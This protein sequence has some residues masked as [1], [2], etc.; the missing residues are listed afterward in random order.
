MRPFELRPGDPANRDLLEQVRPE[1]WSNPDPIERYDIAVLGAGTA[2]LVTAF[3]AAGL[4][5]RTALVER[6][7]LGGDCLN[8][9]CVPSKAV[10]ASARA[11][12]VIRD[13]EDYGLTDPAAGVDFAAVMRR[14]RQIRAE[15]SSHD[16]I[17]RLRDAGVDVFL[18]AGRF[19]GADRLY[20]D[21][22]E[23]RFKRAVIATGARP[24]QPDL[25]GLAQAGCQ[26]NETLFSLTE[27]P[28]RLAVLGAGPIGVEMAQAFARLGT[29]VTL[30]ER[31][32]RILTKD[33]PDA[34]AVVAEALTE[35]GVAIRCGHQVQRV[36]QRGGQKVLHCTGPDDPHVEIQADEILLGVGRAPNVRD[37]GL[38]A[39]GVEFDDQEGIVVD[40]RLA[41]TSRRIF[42]AG[43]CC[44]RYKFTHAADA[45]A[46]IVLANSLFFG[47][48]K[49]SALTV[50]WCTYT[51]PELAHVGLDAERARRE[52]IE[53]DTYQQDF[54][55]VDRALAE[56]RGEG[57]VRVHCRAGS[58]RI[59]GATIVGA[60]AGELI[61][62]LVLAMQTGTGLGRLAQVIQP[63]PTR[64]MAI[65]QLAD[66]YNRTRLTPGVA[67][68]LRWIVSIR[69]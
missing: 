9:G 49:L 50:P 55:Q 57:F 46:R 33:A 53:L 64:S 17:W 23:L 38:Q 14:M 7:L 45:A 47:R 52:G 54:D 40:D 29:R 68:L 5:A 15:I 27:R 69:R 35:D 48:K 6:R 2:G 59:V 34:A 36:E 24:V 32:E 22:A 19:T 31:S 66:Q 60:E 1:K 58:D 10:L 61:G 12:A 56:G 37:L 44:M 20:V 67:R 8:F 62:Q 28:E 13:A 21:G 42:A 4:G 39:A 43:D 18:G 25:P 51:D 30:L 63:Y 16:S 41:T 26:T 3:A 65:R 11:S